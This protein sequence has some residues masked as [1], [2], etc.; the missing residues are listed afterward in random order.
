MRMT[1]VLKTLKQ[2]VSLGYVFER[3]I[4]G[5]R[6]NFYEKEAT[7]CNIGYYMIFKIYNKITCLEMLLVVHM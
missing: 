7:I 6:D 5:N 4:G 3:E 2:F 1:K